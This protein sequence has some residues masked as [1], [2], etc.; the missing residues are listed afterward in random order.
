MVLVLLAIGAVVYSRSEGSQTTE[1]TVTAAAGTPAGN[2]ATTTA[3]T[4]SAQSKTT[5]TKSVP[6]DTI[7][8][9]L[10]SAGAVLI[11][12][13]FFYGR[14]SSIKVLGA[15]IGLTPEEADKV[16][17]QAP[18]TD[19][20]KDKPAAEVADLLPEVLDQVRM[21]KSKAGVTEFSGRQLSS[22]I[23]KAV[24]ALQ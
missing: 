24:Q 18:K 1:K 17:K 12:V 4:P 14:I 3:T 11:L 19:A 13:G 21:E 8:T 10:L 6:S 22:A 16:V 7:L 15:E 20:L 9:A 5:T 23:A 2:T